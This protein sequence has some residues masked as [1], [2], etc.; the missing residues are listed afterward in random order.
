MLNQNS[1][2]P[3]KYIFVSGG[4]ISG[5]GKGIIMSSLSLLLKQAGYT[6]SPMKADMYLNIDAGTMNPLEH[7]ASYFVSYYCAASRTEN[8]QT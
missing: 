8:E 2:K 5:L 6:V 4:V 7:G 3:T 1:N